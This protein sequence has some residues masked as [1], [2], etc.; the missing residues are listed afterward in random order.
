M[1]VY[2]ITVT[3][4]ESPLIAAMLLFIAGTILFYIV[5]WILDILP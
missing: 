1:T 4:V 3:L 2:T 5:R